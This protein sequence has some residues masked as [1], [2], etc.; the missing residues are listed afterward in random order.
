MTDAVP[1]PGDRTFTTDGTQ[2]GLVTCEICGAALLIDPSATFS[3]TKR[4]A[5]WHQ[6]QTWALETLEEALEQGARGE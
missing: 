5:E 1:S 3:A 2:C 4:H 6:N